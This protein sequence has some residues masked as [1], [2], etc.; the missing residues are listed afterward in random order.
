MIDS[1][2]FGSMV[3]NGRQYTS[4]LFIFPNG[5]VQ[6]NWWRRRGHA[7]S[8]KDVQV[9]V[10]TEPEVIIAGTG[11]NGLMRPEASMGDYL[12]KK[13]INFMAGPNE[14]AVA[15]YNQQ[16]GITNVGACFHLTC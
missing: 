5:R 14:Q 7:L 2:S 16:A 13:G 6:D 11:V 10:E 12:E 9:L 4:D 3:I 1:F 15:W 8:R